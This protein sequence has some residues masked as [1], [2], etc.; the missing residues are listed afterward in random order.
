MAKNSASTAFDRGFDDVRRDARSALEAKGASIATADEAAGTIEAR[1][2][3]GLMSWGE[4]IQVAISGS[5]S[6]PTSVTIKSRSRVPITLVDRG[7][8]ARNVNQVLGDIEAVLSSPA[9]GSSP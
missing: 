7:K 2:G 1:V 5:A 8:N 6:A 9:A 4:V 3:M